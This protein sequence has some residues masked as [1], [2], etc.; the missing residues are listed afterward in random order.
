MLTWRQ[1]VLLAFI[2]VCTT[3]NVG[4][5]SQHGGHKPVT[6]PPVAPPG[7]T[8]REAARPPDVTPGYML[9]PVQTPRMPRRAMLDE[10]TDT[11]NSPLNLRRSPSK[12]ERHS[13]PVK[14]ARSGY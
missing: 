9:V 6:A 8:A 14:H 4:V 7:D 3:V 13:S 11:D 2:L 5:L 1:G 12:G 10:G